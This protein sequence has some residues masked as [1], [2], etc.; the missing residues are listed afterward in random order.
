MPE[1]LPTHPDD[2]RKIYHFKSNYNL[3]TSPAIASRINKAFDELPWCFVFP[4]WYTYTANRRF[5]LKKWRSAGDVYGSWEMENPRT[6]ILIPSETSCRESAMNMNNEI[7][8]LRVNWSHYILNILDTEKDLRGRGG[9]NEICWNGVHLELWL[10]YILKCFKN[11]KFIFLLFFIF[12]WLIFEK[13]VVLIY[14]NIQILIKVSSI[15]RK[16]SLYHILKNADT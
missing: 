2:G 3:L 15:E 13:R 1:R 7:T 16:E 6:V 14:I 12:K 9:R 8:F 10:W 11:R 5:N 4:V